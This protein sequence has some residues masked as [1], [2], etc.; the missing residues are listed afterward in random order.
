MTS[1]DR[2]YKFI[3]VT[4]RRLASRVGL[5]GTGSFLV[6]SAI[7]E[8]RSCPEVRMRTYAESL[9]CG[10]VRAALRRT[11]RRAHSDSH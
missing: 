9:D 11:L 7:E 2:P 1:L 10:C 4:V 6:S 5:F 3:G 8:I